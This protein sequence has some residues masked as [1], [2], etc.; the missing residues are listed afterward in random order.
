MYRQ[1]WA[2]VVLAMGERAPK[3]ATG[4]RTVQPRRRRLAASRQGRS[5]GRYSRAPVAGAGEGVAWPPR[6]QQ[7][8][9]RR[10]EQRRYRAP[11]QPVP[12]GGWVGMAEV[13]GWLPSG[14]RAGRKGLPRGAAP[15]REWRATGDAA[16]GEG[17]A[18]PPTGDTP[19]VGSTA[20]RPVAVPIVSTRF[21]K[22]GPRGAAASCLLPVSFSNCSNTQSLRDDRL[23]EP[24]SF[25][26]NT[27][28]TKYEKF[29]H[30][31]L[32]ADA[33]G[34]PRKHGVADTCAWVPHAS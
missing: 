25:D 11:S 19:F 24:I 31:R 15:R 22:P 32:V 5:T 12:E 20:G 18:L 10:A 16:V 7:S 34:G 8:R 9:R 30:I 26:P 2:H 14:G 33:T 27:S 1:W 17:G 4:G 28:H 23:G 3:S 29:I 6:S 13:A 21:Q